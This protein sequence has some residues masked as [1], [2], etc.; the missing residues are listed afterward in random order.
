MVAGQIAGRGLRHR[1]TLAALGT[2]PRHC[3][4][5]ATL[6]DAAYDD[7]PLPVGHGQQGRRARS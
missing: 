6:A 3:F 5:P 2:I 4:V 7:A 1:R